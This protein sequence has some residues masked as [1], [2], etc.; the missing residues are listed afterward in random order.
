VDLFATATFISLIG[1]FHILGVE[2]IKVRL[3]SLNCNYLRM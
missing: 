3:R 1:S 2:E